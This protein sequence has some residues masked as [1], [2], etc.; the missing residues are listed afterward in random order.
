MANFPGSPTVTNCTFSGNSAAFDG[1]G[2]WNDEAE[3]DTTLTNCI[4]WGDTPDEIFD[5]AGGIV[6]VSY[7]NV[8]GG[9][10]GP[11][12]NN[13]EA[14]PC[15]VDAD[16]PDPNLW[17]LRLMPD[18]PCIDKGD[19]NALPAGITTD[20]DGNPRIVD[21]NSDGNPV[22]DMGAYE[23]KPPVKITYVDAVADGNDDGTSWKDAFNHLQDVLPAT[24]A[25]CI[26]RV[27][28]GTYYPDT[29]S[30]DP[31]GTGDRTAAFQLKN[32]VHIIGG[33]I[34]N[35]KS[36]I[37]LPE[38]DPNH[39]EIARNCCCECQ[40]DLNADQCGCYREKC[41]GKTILSGDIGLPNDD[42][43]NSFHVVIGSGTDSTAVLENVTITAGNA[44]GNLPH[45]NGG[46][47]L[48][49]QGSPT[50]KY[51]CFVA[52]NAVDAGGGIYNYLLSS[53]T[54]ISNSFCDNTASWGAGLANFARSGPKLTNCVFNDN[55]A[56]QTGGG[57]SN[58][59]IS[60]PEI[61]NCT[62]YANRAGA[63]GGAVYSNGSD[64]D[65]YNSI[66]WANSAPMG[67]QIALVA[68]NRRTHIG[69]CDLQGGIS[70]V[71]R[72]NATV[73]WSSPIVDNDPLFVDPG[74]C[75]LRLRTNS[76]ACLDAS[77]N[78][79]IDEDINLD[80]DGNPR[81]VNIPAVGPPPDLDPNVLPFADLGAY[82]RPHVIYVDNAAP[83]CDPCGIIWYEP[84]CGID[85]H[86]P[87]AFLQDALAEAQPGDQI[88]VAK[89]KEPYTPDW[90]TDY[91]NLRF[92][93]EQTFNLKKGVALYGGFDG[94]E[95]DV[96][97]R[98]CNTR[99]NETVLSGDLF[100]DDD[101]NVLFGPTFFENSWNIVTAGADT[102]SNTILDGFTIRGGYA[103]GTSPMTPWNKGGGM[104]NLG[105]PTISR[106]LFE[107]NWAYDQG[108]G[109][110]ND[111][112][113]P[114]I[115][116]C[117]FK[118]N[119]TRQ[120][121]AGLCNIGGTPTLICCDFTMNKGAKHGG[122]MYSYLGSATLIKCTFT[123]NG[124]T[125]ENGGA[126][127]SLASDLCLCD[128]NF[129][130]NEADQDGGAMYNAACFMQL[131]NCSFRKN[132]A[133]DDGGA[134]YNFL[135]PDVNLVNSV[136][137]GNKAP[138][139]WGGG[140][141]NDIC[142][143]TELINCTFTQNEADEG[144]GIYNGYSIP[145]PPIDDF[146]VIITGSTLTIRN[147]ILWGDTAVWDGPE[148]SLEE[149]ELLINDSILQ[150]G[151]P[152]IFV[153]GN[154]SIYEWNLLMDDPMFADLDGR[155][156]HNSPAIDRGNDS[157]VPPGV[158]ADLDGLP[159]FIDD[160]CYSYSPWVDNIVDLG[161]YEYLRSDIDESRSV[162][163][164]DFGKFASYWRDTDCGA[165]GGADLT[166][167]QK[168]DLYDLKNFAEYWL[169]G[170]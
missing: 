124:S 160:L 17:N 6:I 101:P 86:E 41:T 9:W 151:E 3:S 5:E 116:D 28:Q 51:C 159:R 161:A 95:T 37:C 63:F 128:C 36:S 61:V 104:H 156:S 167:D 85:W 67:T 78:D 118:D 29:N 87:Y 52:N 24:V 35:S 99:N 79:L 117:E 145:L 74:K 22:V 88:W 111:F 109:M 141:H 154:V 82:E 125:H 76:L 91:P 137:L 80:R 58:S 59:V 39:W 150:G 4:L 149:S 60:D 27:A 166:C 14:D 119:F 68:N 83:P 66:L 64:P 46:G 123:K 155:L 170:K 12:G 18:S 70:A 105:S 43:D 144:G 19:N 55:D 120:Q 157:A 121:G 2:M 30:A 56:R 62:F 65:I 102:D 20:L 33:Y 134:I 126:M 50:V 148:I 49:D 96:T 75:N 11:G 122:G 162:D 25:P 139:G 135:C 94:T 163:F 84:P 53:P 47:M 21:G 164:E 132:E 112:G 73:V 57:I 40:P 44:D 71:Y 31:N 23:W 98:D 54:L 38:D 13:I 81:F 136:F 114:K 1:G 108:G 90:F 165:C 45:N 10:S 8:E 16:N 7:S 115:V 107:Y 77:N 100:G 147:S 42:E 113:S 133:A 158:T 131:Y 129:I 26:V 48:N 143:L 146:N 110:Y 15:F 72:D 69:Y 130:E 142:G 92:H 169:I 106:C 34:G 89:G 153:W 97:D 140:I 103:N 127:A 138:A 32:G 152:N 93:P 168:V